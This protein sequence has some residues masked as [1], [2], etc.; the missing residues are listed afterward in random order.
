[1]PMTR[2]FVIEM[3]RHIDGRD[4]EGLRRFFSPDVIYERPGYPPIEGLDELIH[5]YANVRVIGSGEHQLAHIV[6]DDSAGASW[7]RFV[8]A[9]RDGTPV[10]ERFADCYTFEEGTIKTRSSYFFRPVV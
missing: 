2:D 7:G 1:M 8:G 9:R 3:F 4:W 10:D 6:V 5:F